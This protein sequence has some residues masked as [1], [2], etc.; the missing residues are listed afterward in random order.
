M[1]RVPKIPGRPPRTDAEL[2]ELLDVVEQ[3]FAYRIPELLDTGKVDTNQSG[4]WRDL[5]EATGYEASPVGVSYY[6]PDPVELE[7]ARAWHD[8]C[9]EHGYPTGEL[10]GASSAPGNT[11][12]PSPVHNGRGEWVGLRWAGIRRELLA[13]RAEQ[14]ALAV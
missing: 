12:P 1:T 7:T 13:P 9:R 11:Y 5:R 8:Y 10:C 3:R 4:S 2:R 6:V 14:L